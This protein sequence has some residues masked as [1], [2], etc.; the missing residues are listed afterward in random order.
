MARQVGSRGSESEEL[1]KSDFE[2]WWW[3]LERV[4]G[5]EGRWSLGIGRLGAGS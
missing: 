1:G 5:S 3:R 2:K 4:R